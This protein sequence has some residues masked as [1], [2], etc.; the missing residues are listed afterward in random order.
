MSTRENVLKM[1]AMSCTTVEEILVCAGFSRTVTAPYYFGHPPPPPSA[2]LPAPLPLRPAPLP[3]VPVVF[4]HSLH[5][6]CLFLTDCSSFILPQPPSQARARSSRLPPHRSHQRHSR[7]SP[8]PYASSTF[9]PELPVLPAVAFSLITVVFGYLRYKICVVS[10]LRK[11]GNVLQQTL[12][13]SAQQLKLSQL[14]GTKDDGRVGK[15]EALVLNMSE[16][17]AK[18]EAARLFTPFTPW[19]RIGDP[20][21]PPS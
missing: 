15:H 9:A 10:E 13:D 4:L 17:E 11:E 8:T 12:S 19:A 18:L 16:F 6:I 20:K 1:N 3:P 5:F 14:D 7:L 2:P 21:Q